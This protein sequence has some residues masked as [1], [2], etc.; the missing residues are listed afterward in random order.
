MSLTVAVGGTRTTKVCVYWGCSTVMGTEDMDN[1]DAAKLQTWIAGKAS[2][3]EL[4]MMI[5]IFL[6]R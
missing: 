2:G 1:V 3:A 5:V 6:F 4:M